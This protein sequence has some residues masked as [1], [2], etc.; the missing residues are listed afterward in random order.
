MEKKVANGIMLKQGAQVSCANLIYQSLACISL[1]KIVRQ[2]VLIR[3]LSRTLA[4]GS[5]GVV[6]AILP[7]MH[8]TVRVFLSFYAVYLSFYAVYLSFCA[9]Y[10]SFCAVFVLKLM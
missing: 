7:M 6:V 4:N 9:V 3:N 10:L 5:R 1:R 2:V 8:V